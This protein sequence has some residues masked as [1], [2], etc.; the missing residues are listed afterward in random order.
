MYG[1]DEESYQRVTGKKG[2]Y[3][4]VI[5]TFELLFQHEIHFEIKYIGMQENQDDFFEIRS[6]AEKY[7]AEFSYSMELFPTLNGNGCTKNH[8]ISL[9]KII[10]IESKIPGKKEEYRKL[11]EI[12]NPFKNRQEI[13]LYLCDMA[14]SNFLVDYQGYINPCHKCRMKKWNLLTDDFETAWNDYA[15]LL[16]ERASKNNK[17]LKC[18]Y[19]MMCSPCVVVN[20]LSTG[21]YNKPAETVC[22]LTQMRVEMSHSN[23]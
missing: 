4:K 2:M 13:P 16:K 10:E 6:L 19:L 3:N 11:A 22:R 18:K 5:N 8:M 20:Y 17:C 12:E 7:G 14:I 23:D 15:S 21:D 1:K 9:E